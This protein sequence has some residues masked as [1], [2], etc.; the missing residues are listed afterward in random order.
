M[1]LWGLIGL[2][3]LALFFPLMGCDESLEDQQEKVLKFFSKNKVGRTD[4]GVFKGGLAGG[5]HVASVHGFYFD[6]EV[7]QKIAAL[8]NREEPMTYHC[9]PLN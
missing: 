6:N 4:Y 8:L 9:R 2:S 5:E 3:A 1:R 7:C